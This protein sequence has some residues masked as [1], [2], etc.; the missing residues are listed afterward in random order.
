[1]GQRLA[2]L[3]VD[4]EAEEELAGR[5]ESHGLVVVVLSLLLTLTI[6]IAIA[7][8]TAILLGHRTGTT[9]TRRATT[10]EATGTR[11]ATRA[12]AEAAGTWR[13]TRA[14]AATETAGP[15]S[16]ATGRST[17]TTTTTTESAWA[18]TTWATAEAAW[19]WTAAAATAAT[20]WRAL[21]RLVD[22]QRTTAHGRTV[23]LLHCC[24]CL[25]LSRELHEREA[26]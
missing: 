18:R 23:Q 1:L 3:A 5:I 2:Q 16:A 14:T 13:A 12:T 8:P 7:A 24:S 4:L 11:R 20:T 17:A 25:L 21:A 9:T 6:A 22:D 19:T 10:A 15:R 26:A